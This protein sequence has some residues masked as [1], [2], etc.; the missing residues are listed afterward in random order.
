MNNQL[1]EISVQSINTTEKPVIGLLDWWEFQGANKIFVLSFEV[2]KIR[3]FP[4]KVELKDCNVMIDGQNLSS[5]C[6]S[7]SYKKINYTGNL[8]RVGN[9]AMF[10]RKFKF[11]CY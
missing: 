9:T 3:Y 11:I 7:K 8:G 2:I 5:P 10:P 6:L 4:T 1:E